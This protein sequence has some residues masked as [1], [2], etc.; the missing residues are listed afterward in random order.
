M[1]ENRYHLNDSRFRVN[2]ALGLFVLRWSYEKDAS[3]I[4]K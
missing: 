2:A 4:P 3:G 1:A